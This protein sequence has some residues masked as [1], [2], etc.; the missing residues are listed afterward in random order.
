MFARRLRILSVVL[1]ALDAVLVIAAF[2]AAYQVRAKLLP[3]LAD[4]LPGLPEGPLYPFGFYLP[5][6]VG[7]M[8]IWLATGAL[9]GLY[10]PRELR[11]RRQA[12]L[13]PTRHLLAS[14][15]VLA[16]ALF[17]VKGFYVSRLL[18]LLFVVFDW[19]LQ[20]TVRLAYIEWGP[21]LRE[22]LGDSYHILVVGTGERARE[23]GRI[24]R[25]SRHAGL[26]LAGW[27]ETSPAAAAS[28]LDGLPVHGLGDVPRLLREQVIDEVLF[29]VGR[30][31]L[32]R[33]EDLFLHCEE[34]GVRTRV[35]LQ[36][37]PHQDS[38]V[39]VEHLGA[40]PLLTFSTTPEDE[41]RLFAKRLLDAVGAALLL[42]L[43][44]PLLLLLAALVKL[45]SPGPVLYRQTRC[46]LGGR[47][48]TLAKFR[49]M[50]ADAEQ[51]Q[52]ELATLNEADGPVFKMRNDPR[53]TTLG[54]WMRRL[55]LDELPQ[56]WNILKGDMSFVGPRPP[57][58]SEVE[59]YERWQRRRLRMRPG[60]TC[61]WA[62]E[63]RSDLSF[64]RWMELDMAYI[65]NWSLWLD[66][67]IL[68]RTVPRVLLGRGAA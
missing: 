60:L 3:E 17:F 36:M 40:V 22:R 9:L 53:V 5:L 65:D 43:L 52:A 24:I 50:V 55:S 13:D 26:R 44:S 23:L 63:G 30:E 33:L 64:A 34:E 20:V 38:Q 67:K 62:L 66:L 49:S 1:A 51:R 37:F 16:A 31:E 29:A 45:T 27:V 32:E 2:A 54:R 68:L 21:G 41:L 19:T 39:F 7:I 18:L 42:V 46:G 10:S 4:S 6:L 28:T 61:L 25:E 14:V 56:L 8:A 47:R 12:V 57:L 35:Q 59:K 15:L 48:F 11:E 58:P